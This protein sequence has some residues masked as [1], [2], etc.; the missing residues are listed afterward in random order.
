MNDHVFA[1]LVHDRPEPFAALKRTLGDLGIETF[2]VS[3]CQQAKK[4]ISQCKPHVIF[5]EE[6]LADGSWT[7]VLK[8]VEDAEAP[9]NVIV[10]GVL[11]DT[12]QYISVMERGAFDFV[13]PPFE[14]EPLDFV[15]RSAALDVDRRREA[16]VR[17]AF[18]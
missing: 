12:K 11:P 2:S 14:H 4:L 5:T 6:A 10:V 3:T 17:S 7:R 16:S 13:A 18:G 1:L 8:M 15:T 9:I